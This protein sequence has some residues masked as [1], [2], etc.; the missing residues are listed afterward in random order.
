MNSIAS[1]ANFDGQTPKID[2]NYAA[3]LLIDHQS[4]LFQT[5]GDMPML[6]L[7]AHAIELAKMAS[8]AKTPVKRLGQSGLCCRG[9]SHRKKNSSS[10][11][12]LQASAWPF[13]PSLLCKTVIRFSQWSMP[14]EHIQRWHMKYR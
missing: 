4:G 14:P 12:R 7:R 2:P 6:R 9:Q 10:P 8:L 11:G 3:M 5:V 1:P 13:H